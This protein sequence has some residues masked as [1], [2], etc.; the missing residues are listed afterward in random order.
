MRRREAAPLSPVITT[1]LIAGLRPGTGRR[2]TAASLGPRP[3]R[4]AQPDLPGPAVDR[5]EEAE[6]ESPCPRHA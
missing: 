3:A 2:R 5:I 4:T 6:R 1:A